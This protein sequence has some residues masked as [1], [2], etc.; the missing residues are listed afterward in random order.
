MPTSNTT[1]GDEAQK[2]RDRLDGKK[3]EPAILV[4]PPSEDNAP[5]QQSGVNPVLVKSEIYFAYG[6]R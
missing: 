5:P 3:V 2:I 6:L 1:L 4:N